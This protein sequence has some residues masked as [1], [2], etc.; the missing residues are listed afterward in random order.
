VI[1]E[2]IDI[3]MELLSDVEFQCYQQEEPKY[4]QEE[5]VDKDSTDQKCIGSTCLGCTD[6]ES[7]KRAINDQSPKSSSYQ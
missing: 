3:E 7:C 6:Q 2:S 5:K 4:F 1:S